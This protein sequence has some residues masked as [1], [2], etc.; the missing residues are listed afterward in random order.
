MINSVTFKRLI[1]VLLL[2]FSIPTFASQW[3]WSVQIQ[4]YVSSETND[5]PRAFLWI[6]E[7]CKQ[8]RAVVIGNHNMLEEGILEHPG[9]R[10]KMAQLGIAE[11]WITPG[12]SQVWEPGKDNA[13][14]AFDQMMDSLAMVSGYTELKYAPAIP[15]G[16]SAMAT[17]P[18]NFAAQNNE[19]TLAVLSIHGDAPST[20]LTGYGRPNLDWSKLKIDGIPGL[21]VEGEYEW[22]DARVEP[23]LNY[24]KANPK[25]CISFLCDAGRGHFDYSEQLVEYL[26]LF[27][28]KA[29]KY[30]LPKTSPIGQLVKLIP[31]DSEQGWLANRWH[32]DRLPEAI[33]APNKLYVGNRDSAFWY[34]DKEIAQKTEAIYARQRKKQKQ[35]IGYSVGKELVSFQSK[36]FYGYVPEFKPDSDGVTFHLSVA[37]TDSLRLKRTDKHAKT[38]SGITRICGS[39]TKVN[40]STFIVS[41]YR[42]GMN[43]TKRTA[44]ICLM[45]AND[46]DK[47]YKSA[48]QQLLLHIPYRNKQGL[49][50]RITF[51]SIPNAKQ[52]IKSVDL[53][54][55]ASSGMPVYYYVQEGPAE[56]KNGKLVL[57]TIPPRAKF[58]VKVTVVAWQYGRSIEPKVQTAEPVSRTFYIEK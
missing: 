23:G 50:Q 51:D 31:V 20:N 29:V 47:T 42:M 19:R 21:M 55:T 26:G 15:M 25:S 2:V 58:P 33:A 54:A 12:L 49:E 8:V 43:N 52:W 32:K 53:H 5:H 35:Y 40:D 37:F 41:F 39:V 14:A 10:K 22:W 7:N 3:Q 44:D 34:F 4:N 30:R 17:F 6:P 57:T 1:L 11:I 46:G 36:H 56:L 38:K 9:F 24:K 48:V 16:H 18:W 28:E 13:Q 45:A 27:V